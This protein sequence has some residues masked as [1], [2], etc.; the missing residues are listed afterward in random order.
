MQALLSSRHFSTLA[1]DTFILVHNVCAGCNS[2]GYKY[3]FMPV[4][5]DCPI[6]TGMI[7]YKI[8]ITFETSTNTMHQ[9]INIHCNCRGMSTTSE[10]LHIHNGG[11]VLEYVDTSLP[12]S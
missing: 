5:D 1:V 7:L 11:R 10:S 9:N 4:S 3:N 2:E 12:Q 6:D 8:A